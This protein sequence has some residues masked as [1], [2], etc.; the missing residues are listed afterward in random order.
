MQIALY[1]ISAFLTNI[2]FSVA[3]AVLVTFGFDKLGE[4]PGSPGIMLIGLICI[5]GLLS[6]ITAAIMVDAKTKYQKE[7]PAKVSMIIFLFT[8]FPFHIYGLYFSSVQLGFLA[9]P[10]GI[11]LVIMLY[12]SYIPFFHMT[13][14]SLINTNEFVNRQATTGNW[15]PKFIFLAFLGMLVLFSGWF[16]NR[17]LF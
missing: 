15:Y 11:L 2:A 8:Y 5:C 12:F 9:A 4:D 16:I 7:F 6:L 1:F 14:Q 13:A 3:T 17:I 10:L